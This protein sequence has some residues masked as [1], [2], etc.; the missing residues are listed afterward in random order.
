MENKREEILSRLEAI[1]Q[2][3]KQLKKQLNDLPSL[4]VGKWYKSVGTYLIYC[5]TEINGDW[6]V[7]YGFENG[8]WVT[9]KETNNKEECWFDLSED[10]SR[11]VVPATDKEVETALIAEAKK[12]G[13]KEGV[14]CN[15]SIIK[16]RKFDNF[17]F[18][19][20]VFFYNS[21][22]NSLEWRRNGVGDSYNEWT[23]F[24][25]GKWAEIIEEPKTVHIPEG[26]YTET[27]LKD[28]LN[29]LYEK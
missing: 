17:L 5:V 26:D 23:L 9:S 12:R 13:F 1:K 21:K 14:L 25:K 16:N 27:Q 22:V 2:E 11:W 8:K 24:Y 6:V 20:R 29:N 28:I 7:G 18:D 4:E 15:N 10:I 19:N 3:K